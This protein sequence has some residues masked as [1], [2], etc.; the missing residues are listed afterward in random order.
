MKFSNLF[1]LLVLATAAT[2]ETTHWEIDPVHSTLGFSIRHLMVSNVS[3]SFTQF[4]GTVDV[5][6][7]DPAS[8][9][10]KADIDT[11]SINTGNVKR[12]DHLRN[13]DF[14]DAPKFP[15]ISFV[16]KKIEKAGEKLV[17]TGDLTMHGVTKE[18]SLDVEQPTEAV[19]GPGG[20]LRRGIAATG[21][22]NRQEF[23]LTW[24]K[25][26]DG[27]GLMLG[28]DVKLTL[29]LA[30]VQKPATAASPAASPAAPG[31]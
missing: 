28:N 2:A 12:D 14:F 21:K 4:A 16:S 11:S 6:P 22:L 3:G 30:L 23:G 18:V 20:A 8:A 5:D 24:S 31:R 19:K 1:L 29:D 15:K 10:I 13:P 7:A 26:M 27:G 17:L 9:V 25:T